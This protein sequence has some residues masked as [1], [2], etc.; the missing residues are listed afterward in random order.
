VEEETSVVG[1]QTISKH[2]E[3]MQYESKLCMIWKLLRNVSSKDTRFCI[4]KET[5]GKKS[6]LIE[7][8]CNE[9]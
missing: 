8:G 9:K 6:V 3:P 4:T 2:T 5:I 7:C 1:K